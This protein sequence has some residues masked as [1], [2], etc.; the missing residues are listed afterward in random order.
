MRNA[1]GVIELLFV[2]IIIIILYFTFF[3]GGKVGRKNPFDDNVRINTQQKLIDNKLKEIEQSK[4][5]KQNIEKEYE[6]GY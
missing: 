6:V 4:I 2:V 3:T 5:I 1:G